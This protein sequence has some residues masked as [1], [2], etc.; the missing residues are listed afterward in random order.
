MTYKT[1]E[2]NVA[3]KLVVEITDIDKQTVA[4]VLELIA[5]QIKSGFHKG[6]N[7]TTKELEGENISCNYSY[8]LKDIY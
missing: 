5:S 8:Q 3:L 2:Q 6:F 1:K 4:E 7:E